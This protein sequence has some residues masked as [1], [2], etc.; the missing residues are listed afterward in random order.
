MYIYIDGALQLGT[1]GALESLLPP[2]L[3]ALATPP[4]SYNSQVVYIHAML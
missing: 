3:L 2:L 1:E 4:L